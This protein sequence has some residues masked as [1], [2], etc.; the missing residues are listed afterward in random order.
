MAMGKV[1]SWQQTI[2]A[3]TVSRT[4][5]NFAIKQSLKTRFYWAEL[6]FIERGLAAWTRT[7]SRERRWQ[8]NPNS[9]SWEY[10]KGIFSLDLGDSRGTERRNESDVRFGIS[11]DLSIRVAFLLGTRV[12]HYTKGM[13]AEQGR[14]F[15]LN[16][17]LFKQSLIANQTLTFKW[18]FLNEPKISLLF[19]IRS[20]CWST[21]R[22]CHFAGTFC[23]HSAP[24]VWA[25]AR[26]AFLFGV[27]AHSTIFLW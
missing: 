23:S 12:T 27:S 17:L 25:V 8:R 6:L 15:S 13:E 21:S 10:W 4:T 14:S 7:S 11:S 3:C 16:E 19:L 18:V 1:P 22:W 5:A 26:F 9:Y 24:S 2:A 20:K